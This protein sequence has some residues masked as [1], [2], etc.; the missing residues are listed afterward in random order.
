MMVGLVFVTALVDGILIDVV[1]FGIMMVVVVGIVMVVVVR[2]VMVVVA[3]GY[4]AGKEIL[5]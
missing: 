2:V 5:I 3:T 4:S 1:V